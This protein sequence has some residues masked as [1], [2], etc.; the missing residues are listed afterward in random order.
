MSEIFFILKTMVLTAVLVVVLQIRVENQS[1]EDKATEYLQSTTV[2]A[3]LQET[4]D[5]ALKVVKKFW[6]TAMG[7]MNSKFMREFNSDQTPGKRKLGVQLERSKE[8]FEEQAEKA[9][10]SLRELNK[11]SEDN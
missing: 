3:P 2:L 4:A 1:L 10:Q 8:Y 7:S 6:K 9:Q 5:G 11:D